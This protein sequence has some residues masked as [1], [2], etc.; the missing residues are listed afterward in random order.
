MKRIF[1]AIIAT[2]W[3]TAAAQAQIGYKG[4]LSLELLPGITHCGGLTGTIRMAAFLSDHSNIGV[5]VWSDYTIYDAVHD[6]SF[7]TSQWIGV[8]DYRY[9][10][11]L[12]RFI[13]MPGAGVFLGVE[14]CDSISKL[15]KILTYGNQFIYGAVAC[16]G[17]EYVLGRSWALDVEP[18]IHYLLRTHF[19]NLK[20]SMNIG[21]KC[22]F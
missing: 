4:Q 20:L 16:I 19:D 8:L 12:S 21:I 2:I 3:M 18:R 1:L 14:R 10:F 6:D 13:F 17:I 9:A 11:P 5:G 15:G 7:E 22:Y